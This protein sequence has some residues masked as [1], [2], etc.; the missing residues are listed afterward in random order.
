MVRDSLPKDNNS[1]FK[2]TG[3]L[4]V[5]EVVEQMVR[6]IE[7]EELAG[8]SIKLMPGRKPLLHN[9]RKA[10]SSGVLTGAKL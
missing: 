8:D 2:M 9:G 7:D 4:T 5:D 3:V 1:V 10:V 6:C